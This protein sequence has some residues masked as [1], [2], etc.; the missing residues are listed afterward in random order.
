MKN[1]EAILLANDLRRKL[2][3]ARKKS[4][5]SRQDLADQIGVHSFTLACWENTNDRW[6]GVVTLIR[7]AHALGYQFGPKRGR[8]RSKDAL[9]NAERCRRYR[10]RR[11]STSRQQCEDLSIGAF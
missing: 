6:P 2:V 8:H 10:Q 1:D 3:A 5:R 9:T 7:W 4:G 11:R